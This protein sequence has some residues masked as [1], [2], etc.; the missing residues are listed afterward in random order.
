M[1]VLL[2]CGPSNIFE[3]CSSPP[4]P[5]SSTDL[6]RVQLTSHLALTHVLQETA[7][8]NSK[9]TSL[10]FKLVQS[11]ANLSTQHRQMLLE[12]APYRQYG[13]P[14]EQPKYSR[15]LV[16]LLHAKQWV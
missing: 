7:V 1:Q 5:L 6:E 11:I 4:I 12:E 14:P 15:K 10:L 2:K 13:D 16:D 3:I 9:Q 8:N